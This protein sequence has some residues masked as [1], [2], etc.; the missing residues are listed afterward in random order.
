MI[1]AKSG[2]RLTLELLG[3][4]IED[5]GADDVGRQQVRRELD[6]RE[7]RVN[8]FGERL[9]RQRLRQSGH[10]LEQDVP[11]GK[12]SHQQ[13]LDHDI[14]SYDALG[15]FSSDAANRAGINGAG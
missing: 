7:R 13:A 15:D 12:E 10:A 4:L 8:D 11:P 6:A 5:H 2:P 1:W 3:L 9:H 14:L